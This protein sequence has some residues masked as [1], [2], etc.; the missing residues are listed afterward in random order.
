MAPEQTV[1][2]YFQF[3]KTERWDRSAELFRED[4][5]YRTP[6]ARPR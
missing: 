1:E 3:A 6:D 5:A 2:C 4:A